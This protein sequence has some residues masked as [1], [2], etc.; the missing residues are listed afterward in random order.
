MP[1]AIGRRWAR[2]MIMRRWRE[3]DYL[4]LVAAGERVGLDEGVVI[5]VNNSR[6]LPH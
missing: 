1:K 2:M 5:A 3:G 4:R 6:A